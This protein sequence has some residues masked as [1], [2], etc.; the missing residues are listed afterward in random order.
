ME[1]G[2][3]LNFDGMFERS[4]EDRQEAP[5]R[6]VFLSVEGNRTER[7]YFDCVE[8]YRGEIGIQKEVHIHPLKRSRKDHYS[9]PQDVLELL[10]EYVQLRQET[11]LP[12]RLKKVIPAKYSD[13]FVAQYLEGELKEKA[14]IEQF[15][16]LLKQVGVDLAYANFLRTY[17]SDN[18]VFCIVIDR[19]YKSHSVQQM[20][21]ISQE[22]SDKGYRCFISTPLFEFWLLLHLT[23]LSRKS[24]EELDKIL[25]NDYV[26]NKHTYTSNLV[27]NIAGHSKNITEKIFQKFYLP[28]IDYAIKQAKEKYACSVDDLIGNEESDNASMGKLGTN[29][30]ELFDLLRE[31]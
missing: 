28:K 10:E 19:D 3:R 21:K 17:K 18:D 27:S 11:D 31:V 30:P 20:R 5:A 15:E 22:C 13:E 9:A 7:Q 26:S 25:I 29:I 16:F 23:D 2:F 24:I 12:K 1:N 8:K 6:I 4:E 14:E